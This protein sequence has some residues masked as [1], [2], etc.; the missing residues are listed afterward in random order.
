MRAILHRQQIRRQFGITQQEAQ[1]FISEDRN[2]LLPQGVDRPES[3][4]P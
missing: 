4:P 2:C 1:S 3:R